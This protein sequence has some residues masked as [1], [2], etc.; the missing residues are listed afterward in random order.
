MTVVRAALVQT[1]WTGDK[2]SM[3]A[4]HEDYARQAA[5]QGTQVICFQELFYG[6]YFCQVQDAAYYEYAEEIPNGPT[7]QRFQSVAKELGVVLVLPMYE[8]E[9]EGVLYNTAAVI[10]ADGSYLGKLYRNAGDREHDRGGIPVRIIEY[11]F[12][13]P[14]RPGAGEKHRLLTTLLNARKHPAKTLVEL[15]HGR[16][17]EELAIDELKTHESER[18]VLR[19]QTPAGVVQELYGLMLGHYVLRTLMH[20]AAK[21]VPVSPLQLRMVKVV[22]LGMATGMAARSSSWSSAPLCRLTAPV[23]VSCSAAGVPEESTWAP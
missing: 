21:K 13:D 1:S 20:E 22:P 19:S 2:E 8:K 9:Q 11:R 10:D 23:T 17:E 6:P 4:A 16:W 7:T 3:I 14:K 5:A 18:P 12:D 15:Y